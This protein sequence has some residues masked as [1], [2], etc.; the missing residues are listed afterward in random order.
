VIVVSNTSPI[1]NLT[2]IGLFHLLHDLYGRI[3]IPDGVWDELNAFNQAWPGSKEVSAADWIERQAPKN[4]Q[5]VTALRRDLDRGEAETI[6]LALELGAD[7]VLLDERDGRYAA[8]RFGLRVVGVLGILIEAK[9]K[10]FIQD[11][12]P[13][14]DL[15]RQN[16]GFYI[17]ETLYQ[18]VLTMV[19]E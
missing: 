16:A 5:I 19:G 11:V 14:L 17:R 12:K 4:Q 9:S 2:A 13:Y 10:G 18:Y 15:L 1:T 7:L 8:Q 3:Y 6:A